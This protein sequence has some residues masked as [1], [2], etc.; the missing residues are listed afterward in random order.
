MVQHATDEDRPP[1]RKRPANPQAQ[2]RARPRKTALQ[3]GQQQGRRA[4]VFAVRDASGG[5]DRFLQRPS[6]PEGE[7]AHVGRGGPGVQHVTVQV[8]DQVRRHPGAEQEREASTLQEAHSETE[9]RWLK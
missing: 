7:E 9:E 3:E 1:G 8:Q 5:A 4:S 2:E 6:D